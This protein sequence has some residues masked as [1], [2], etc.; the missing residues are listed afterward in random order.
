METERAIKLVDVKLQ[1]P[2]R[3]MAAKK[4]KQVL[5]SNNHHNALQKRQ[6]HILE[7]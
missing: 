3:V 6:V 1:N 2:Y 5:N 7:N 4:L